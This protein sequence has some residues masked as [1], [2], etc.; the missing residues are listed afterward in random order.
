M[1]FEKEIFYHRERRDRREEKFVLHFLCALCGLCGKNALTVFLV[2]LLPAIAPAVSTQPSGLSAQSTVNEVLDALDV[3]G[4][5]IQDF[6]AAVKLAETDNSVGSSTSNTGT[7]LLQRK[8][9]DDARIRVV[10]TKF[11]DENLI[12]KINHQYTLDNGVLVDRDYDK[13]HETRTQVLK[14]GEKL[15][16]FKLGVGPFPLPL[17]QKKEDVLRLFDVAKIPPA[18]D[19]PP[20]TVHLQLTPKAHTSFAKDFLNIDVWVECATS[21]PRRIQ[22]VDINNTSTRTTD[23]TNVKI[24]TGVSDKDFQEPSLPSGWDVVEGP[25]NQ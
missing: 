15:D 4:K 5:S 13:K 24:N 14:P 16:L 11:Q 17:G 8:T 23:L 20:G 22:T 25:M 2:I 1:T 7:I 3:R 21:M 12:T 6:S 9:P 18:K 10:F 19:D